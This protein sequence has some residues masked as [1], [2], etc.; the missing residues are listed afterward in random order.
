[1]ETR[2]T[3]TT[4]RPLRIGIH[5]ALARNGVSG[6]VEQHVIGL[7]KALGTL[8][9]GNEKYTLLT[10]PLNP[11][12]LA[13]YHGD[14]Q[15]VLSYPAPPEPSI[16]R[17]IVTGIEQSRYGRVVTSR[18]TAALVGG[19]GT[20]VIHEPPMSDG[21]LESLNL[22]VMHFPYQRMIRT[23]VPS[24]YSPW[25]LQHLHYPCFFEPATVAAREVYYPIACRA[26]QR[27]VVA[28]GWMKR[29][30]V[31]K[32]G[33]E[34]RK[35]HV[36]PPAPS[37]DAYHLSPPRDV[38]R[39]QQGYRLPS[40]F[41]YYPATTFPHKN[42]LR[43]FAALAQLRDENDLRINLVC[44]GGQN[45]FWPCLSEEI[46]RLNLADQVS[47]LGFVE[48]AVVRILYRTASFVVLPT[49]FEGGCLPMLEAFREGT[50]V[51]CSTVTH[52]PEQAGD[53]ALLFDPTSVDSIADAMHAME[54]D[55]LLRTTLVERGRARAEWFS[56]R[57]AALTYRALYRHMGGRVLVPEDKALLVSSQ[58]GAS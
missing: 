41:A 22:D 12:W 52:L 47:F 42:H 14:N 44:T 7:V 48:P 15:Q 18:L 58:S 31:E 2:L 23:R 46:E 20:H 5:C 37:V 53:A 43:L 17:R 35:V 9:D 38:E 6:G 25:D 32:Y 16:V 13:P 51:A 33:L 28:S 29:D 56:A 27:V 49:L 36:I 1:M 4:E 11:D 45:E 55:S 40:Q 8:Q 30:I 3:N 57:R 34:A 54:H 19:P 24:I 26:A 39:V 21:Y 50:P 10:D